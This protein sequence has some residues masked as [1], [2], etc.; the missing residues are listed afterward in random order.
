MKVELTIK[1]GWSETKVVV[2]GTR[3]QVE[4]IIEAIKEAFKDELH[5]EIR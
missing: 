5:T 2:E 1:A 4:K 3:Y